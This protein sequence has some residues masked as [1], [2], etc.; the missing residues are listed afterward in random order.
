MPKTAVPITPEKEVKVETVS[1][2]TFFR[3][4]IIFQILL[5]LL[6]M[7]FAA[8][9]Y[10]VKNID[11][12]SNAR[13]TFSLDLDV[14]QN[15]QQI[16]LPGFDFAMRFLSKMGDVYWGSLLI[17]AF[18]FIAIYLKKQK[19]ALLILLSAI[20]V[21]VLSVILKAYVS[22]P[23]PDPEIISQIGNFLREDSFPSGHVLHAIGLYGFLIFLVI[24]HVKSRYL[25]AVL[26]VPLLL[27]I[28]FMGVSR[29]YLGAHWFSDTLGSY[30][31]GGVWLYIMVFIYHRIKAEAQKE[32]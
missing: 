22:R 7:A 15:I 18:F 30:L 6:I 2:P 25:E 12:S 24:V 23:R 8:L 17:T 32:K 1:R 11:Y 9:T 13:A 28:I 3:R 29:I 16:S 14:T 5:I 19:D 27:I 4:S 21:G 10:F 26:V 31:I 20:G